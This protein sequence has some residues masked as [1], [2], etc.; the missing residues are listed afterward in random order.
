MKRFT[1]FLVPFAAA[2]TLGAA[3]SAQDADRHQQVVTY[4]ADEL[5]TESGRD[6]LRARLAD[7]AQDVCQIQDISR[8]TAMRLTRECVT[9][10][11]TKAEAEL[12]RR[13]AASE[14]AGRIRLAG[15]PR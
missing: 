6:A 8:I 1:A 14:E 9:D 3:A 7:A 10:A 11:V 4:K 2:A 13:I 15:A 5:A 12:E